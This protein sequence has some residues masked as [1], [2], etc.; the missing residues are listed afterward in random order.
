MEWAGIRRELAAALR[1]ADLQ[2]DAVKLQIIQTG[3]FAAAL[4]VVEF[5]D[6]ES[7]SGGHALSREAW[8]ATNLPVEQGTQKKKNHPLHR[9]LSGP[10]A[11][12]AFPS[13]SPEHLAAAL[14]ILTPTPG[15]NSAFAAPRRRE[16]P[17]LY[18]GPVQSGLQKLMM[19]GARVEGRAVDGEEVR[20]VGGLAKRG[21]LEGLRAEV[22]ALLQGVGMGL[23]GGLEGVGVGVWGTLE[24]RRIVME[25]EGE[26]KEG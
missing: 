4:R 10:I 2:P 15:R 9:L 17:G 19:L 25:E 8:E 24:G 26:G 20:F 12:C 14:K 11:V 22:V 5:H 1:R 13:L 7:G 18:E 3:M 16:A 21:G 6:P 23:V